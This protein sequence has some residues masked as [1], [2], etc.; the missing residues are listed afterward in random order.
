M[1]EPER[2]PSEIVVPINP[3]TYPLSLTGTVPGALTAQRVAA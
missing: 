2:I 1:M 3:P